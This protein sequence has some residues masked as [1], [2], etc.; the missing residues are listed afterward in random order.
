MAYWEADLS[1][2]FSTITPGSYNSTYTPSGGSASSV[3][4]LMDQEE[5]E[6]PELD[7][8]SVISMAPP[9]RAHSSDVSGIS[10]GDAFTINSKDYTIL[11]FFDDGA[12]ST[13]IKLEED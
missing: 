13:H 5:A 9:I 10:N 12:G 2:L 6:Q 3:V 4:I 7:E 11:E 8:I 1:S